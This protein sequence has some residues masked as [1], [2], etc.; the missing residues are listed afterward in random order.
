MFGCGAAACPAFV[1]LVRRC[2]W[3]I[4]DTR[5]V[6]MSGPFDASLS[7]GAGLV[8]MVGEDA[9]EAESTEVAAAPRNMQIAAAADPT[10]PQPPLSPTFAHP[11]QGILKPFARHPQDDL[12]RDKTQLGKA[13]QAK[14]VVKKCE[15]NR[16][17][18]QCKDCRGSGICEHNRQRRLCA[19]CGGRGAHFPLPSATSCPRISPQSS[20]CMHP[21][22]ETD[23]T[24]CGGWAGICEH[25]RIKT[26]C[27][28]CGGPG[29]CEHKRRRSR[30]K[31]CGGALHAISPRLPSHTHPVCA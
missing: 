29:I 18:S 2:A 17:K 21:C 9:L 13:G 16:Q 24:A 25:K 23:R 22:D 27:R 10:A 11:H 3:T 28:D 5:R 26:Q 1:L 7:G 6:G 4:A 12:G 31:D 8:G 19:E 20:T 15:H 30:C 14:R